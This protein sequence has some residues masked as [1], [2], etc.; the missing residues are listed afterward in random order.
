M[1]R[2]YAEIARESL[3]KKESVARNYAAAAAQ[4]SGL[5]VISYREGRLNVEAGAADASR[6][7]ISPHP[8][9]TASGHL[10]TG[11]SNARRAPRPTSR[12]RD[13]APPIGY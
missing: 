2:V 6:A 8:T 7:A 5:W 3:Q 4:F 13:Y 10:Q 9:A 1:G 11:L 12:F